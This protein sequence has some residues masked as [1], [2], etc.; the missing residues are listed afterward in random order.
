M[1]TDFDFKRIGLLFR[2]EW[3]EKRWYYLATLLVYYSCTTILFIWTSLTEIPQLLDEPEF[4]IHRIEDSCF[5]IIT[6]LSLLVAASRGTAFFGDCNDKRGSTTFLS[7]PASI[8]EKFFVKW[9]YTVPITALA[10][11]ICVFLADYTRIF[12]CSQM[13]PDANVCQ[14]LHWDWSNK[15]IHLWFLISLAIQSVYML[16]STMWK[17]NGFV[18]TSALL[19]ALMAVYIMTA[20]G[21]LETMASDNYYI[22]YNITPSYWLFVIFIIGIWI[23]TYF[24]V[25]QTD[26]AYGHMRTT[27]YIIIGIAV[28]GLIVS[29]AAPYFISTKKPNTTIRLRSFNERRIHHKLPAFNHLIIKDKTSIQLNKLPNDTIKRYLYYNYLSSITLSADSSSNMLYVQKRLWPYLK[30]VSHKD[31]LIVEFNYPLHNYINNFEAKDRSKINQL[32]IQLDME[33]NTKTLKSVTCEIPVQDFKLTGFNQNNLAVTCN[34]AQMDNCHI[35]R[36]YLKYMEKPEHT[37]W[38]PNNRDLNTVLL[39]NSKIGQVYKEDK[40][41]IVHTANKDASADSIRISLK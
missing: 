12:I 25:K 4:C 10:F 14:P 24:R 36:L 9:F 32:E 31:T 1:K 16:G 38:S 35:D 21:I 34:G 39:T 40:N 30:L 13:Y 8:E 17:K 23:L 33:F 3:E 19:M 28:L 2:K 18:K 15:D 6:L 7:L 27:S 41:G 26:V 11:L 29:A 5:I 37:I 20:S 22:T